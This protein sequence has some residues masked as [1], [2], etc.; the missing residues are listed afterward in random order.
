MKNNP[1]QIAM[2]V[3]LGAA[4]TVFILYM[5]GMLRIGE[6]YEGEEEED[7]EVD[8]ELREL[9][10]LIAESD[11]VDVDEEVKKNAEETK[12]AKEPVPMGDSDDEDDT[13]GIENAIVQQLIKAAQE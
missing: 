1:Q 5:S 4:L 3:A 10:E 7:V 9:E 8:E 2:Y 13:E 11:D 6:R 12:K